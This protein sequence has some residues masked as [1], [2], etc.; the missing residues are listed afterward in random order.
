[1]PVPTVVA[2]GRE[3]PALGAA[4][5]LVE[6]LAGTSDPKQIV[7]APRERARA[8]RRDRRGARRGPPHAHRSLARAGG[9]GAA[10]AAARAARR[11]SASRTPR[12]SSPSARSGPTGRRRGRALV[13]GDFRMGNL[14]V[15]RRPR[16]RRARLGARRT[17][18]TRSRTSAG[19]ACRP[20]ASRD[21]TCPPPASARASSCSP[22]TRATPASPSTAGRCAA[23]SSP[24][25]CAGA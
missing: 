12:S 7:A 11:A 17:S 10:R 6:A 22:P 13:H 25:R 14:M 3:D 4:W 5:T 1:M 20:G 8:A 24:A 18:A 9:R 15:E 23:G 2:H 21:R 19:C 16:H